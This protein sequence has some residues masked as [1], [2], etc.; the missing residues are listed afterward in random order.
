ML[1]PVYGTS[2]HCEWFGEGSQTVVVLHGWGTSITVMQSVIDHLAAR[3]L[4][5]LALDFPGFGASPP[6]PFA[7][8]VPEYA[9][10]TAELLEQLQVKSPILLGHS[11][12]GRVILYLTGALGFC[13]HRLI[14]VD[15]AGIKP[16]PGKASRK[17]RLFKMGKAT[18]SVFPKSIREP[19]LERLREHFGS[20]DY[21]AAQGVMRDVLVKTLS[22]DLAP[23]LPD[24]PTEALLIWGSAD[25]AT[26]LWQGQR[27]EQL[28]PN[29]GLA[30][31][32]GA[33]HYTFFDNPLRFYAILD[34]YLSTLAREGTP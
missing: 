23:L 8:G 33:G 11:F 25:T 18:L 26:P 28:L 14:L 21:R 10:A 16:P 9:K 31:I 5:V 22:L 3:G 32:E 12:G 15:A 27:M 20:A 13:A 34:S 19:L 17:T 7:W 4:R 29:A 1:V 24:I 30:V 6:P 2:V